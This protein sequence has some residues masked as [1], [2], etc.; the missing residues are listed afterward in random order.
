MS[1]YA[2]GYNQTNINIPSASDGSNRAPVVLPITNAITADLTVLNNGLA[3][4]QNTLGSPY[5]QPIILFVPSSYLG[6]FPGGSSFAVRLVR[7]GPE[8]PESAT[9]DTSDLTVTAVG[10]MDQISFDIS[11]IGNTT[12]SPANTVDFFA[13]YVGV[14][15]GS[16]RPSSNTEQFA[17]IFLAQRDGN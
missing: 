16:G 17:G 9:A 7:I 8:T 5:T 12:A 15:D 13:L 4:V 2:S 1:A 10:E 3:V 14:N 11:G 6:S